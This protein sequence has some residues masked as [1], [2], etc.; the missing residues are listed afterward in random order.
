MLTYNP[1]PDMMEYIS[2]SRGYRQ[3]M[4]NLSAPPGLDSFGPE[5]VD[6]YEIGAK[7]T[8]RGRMPATVNFA[9]Y[10]ADFANQQIAISAFANPPVAGLTSGQG[11]YNLGQSHMW[12]LELEATVRP[13]PSFRVDASAGYLQTKVDRFSV[14]SSIGVFNVIQPTVFQ[15]GPLI[16]SPKYKTSLT[17]TYTLPLPDSAGKV[18]FSAN[19]VYQSAQGI[20][21]GQQTNSSGVLTGTPFGKGDPQNLV[22]LNLSWESIFDSP[23]DASFFVTNLLDDTYYTYSTGGYNSPGF[24]FDAMTIGSQPRFFGGRV[25]LRFGADAH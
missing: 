18:E 7:N 20:A 12:G 10:Y 4:V 3:G 2:Y 6:V 5:S 19:Y 23:V 17:G 11:L 1:T 13:F 25:K 9:V 16:F 22:N 21:L 8:F 14:P 24:G 15:G